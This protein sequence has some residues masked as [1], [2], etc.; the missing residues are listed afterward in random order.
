MFVFADLPILAG[1]THLKMLII[2]LLQIVLDC[3]IYWPIKKYRTYRT[4]PHSIR[5]FYITTRSDWSVSKA[6]LLWILES[7]FIKGY[8]PGL[9][10]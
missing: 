5:F 7:R 1:K 2:V 3:E 4:A 8:L 6:V 9:R 10:E